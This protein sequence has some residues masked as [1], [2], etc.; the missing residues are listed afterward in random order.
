MKADDSGEDDI[1]RS[2]PDERARWPWGE[3]ENPCK[4]NSRHKVMRGERKTKNLEEDWQISPEVGDIREVIG[5]TVYWQNANG[6]YRLSRRILTNTVPNWL[7]TF[8]TWA[9]K[10]PSLADWMRLWLMRLKTIV[11]CIVL[12]QILTWQ[13]K[14][15]RQASKS[16]EGQMKCWD[17]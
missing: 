2:K 14:C 11:N 16:S 1:G 4:S 3:E 5:H 7:K 13:Q 8:V 12:V 6:M 10:S 9:S 15:K 17:C